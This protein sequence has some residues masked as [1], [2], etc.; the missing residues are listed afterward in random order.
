M[1]SRVSPSLLQQAGGR[2]PARLAGNRDEQVLGADVLVLEALGFGLRQIGDE[3]QA[4][5]DRRAGAAVHLRLLSEQLPRIARD[6]CRIDLQLPQQ[7]G[8]DAVGLLD[9]RD[10]QVLGLDLRMILLSRRAA[11]P[12]STASWAFSVYL[13]RFMTCSADVKSVLQMI[14]P[15]YFRVGEPEVRLL[16]ARA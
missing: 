13:F 8:D 12:P 11:A 9:E 7:R 16:R 6:G 14:A 5:R 15:A 2:G 1:R 10:E 4:R 3:L